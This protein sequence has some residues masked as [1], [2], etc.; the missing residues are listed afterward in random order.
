LSELRWILLG[1]GAALIGGIWWWGGRRSGQARGVAELRESDLGAPITALP[2]APREPA[3]STHVPLV[4][5]A[6]KPSER[7]PPRFE[8]LDTTVVEFELPP[9]HATKVD[10]SMASEAS[11]E[12][13]DVSLESSAELMHG[14]VL[15]EEIDLP[16]PLEP[17]LAP[18]PPPSLQPAVDEMHA[19]SP[20]RFA[21]SSEPVVPPRG[22]PSGRFA[23]PD[24]PAPPASPLQKIV[25]LRLSAGVGRWPGA[26]L[27]DALGE[28]KLIH[29]RYGIFHRMHV[30]GRSIFSVASITEPGVFEPSRMPQQEFQGLS[31]FAVLPGPLPPVAAVDALVDAA[32]ALRERMGGQLQ[33]DKGLP[34]SPQSMVALRTDAEAFEAQL[35][36][37]DGQA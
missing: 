18:S 32:R 19:D 28:I 2:P 27:R 20:G 23:R 16:P 30:D 12:F 14:P 31:F 10:A 7:I 5:S 13:D 3:V 35:R 26:L 17:P 37:G 11:I 25:T 21:K 9:M 36:A 1:L 33:N 24:P 29:G 22:D 6:V 4:K 8:D 15:G 34:L